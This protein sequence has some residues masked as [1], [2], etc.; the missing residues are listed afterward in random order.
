MH[1]RSGTVFTNYCEHAT[2]NRRDLLHPIGFA[3]SLRPVSPRPSTR[4]SD[5]PPSPSRVCAFAGLAAD[6]PPKAQRLVRAGCPAS[7]SSGC[8]LLNV[9]KV[10][11]A[12]AS[13]DVTVN[14]GRVLAHIQAHRGQAQSASRGGW[15]TCL[16]RRS[17][18]RICDSASATALPM[19]G[20]ATAAALNSLRCVL[21]DDAVSGAGSWAASLSSYSGTER[22]RGKARS[23]RLFTAMGGCVKLA[24][25]WELSGSLLLLDCQKIGRK[26][27]GH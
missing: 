16:Y 6:V 9:A 4:L 21:S 8:G 13:N 17:L 19:Y 10:L 20:R 24:K 1:P 18:S 26:H 14:V 11:N 27:L 7:A 12:A 2:H 5:C 15:G 25:D 3:R 22:S 23:S